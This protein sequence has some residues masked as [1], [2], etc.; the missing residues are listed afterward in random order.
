L[1]AK[2][3]GDNYVNVKDLFW[4]KIQ[5]EGNVYYKGNPIIVDTVTGK[6]QLINNN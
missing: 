1:L 5:Q 6:G 2:G 4:V 3:T